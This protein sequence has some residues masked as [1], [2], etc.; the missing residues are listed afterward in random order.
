LLA[1]LAQGNARFG[2][3]VHGFCLMTKHLQLVSRQIS[4]LVAR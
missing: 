2:L 4:A 1:L 3:W